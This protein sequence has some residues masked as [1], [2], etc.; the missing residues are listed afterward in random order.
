[1]VRCLGVSEDRPWRRSLSLSDHRH[2]RGNDSPRPP[3]VGQLPVGIPTRPHP[4]TGRRVQAQGKKT[5]NLI[6]D[7]LALVEEHTGGNPMGPQKW[8]RRSLRNLCRDLKRHGHK[9]CAATI[10]KLLKKHDYTPK[11]N[12]KRFTGPRHPDRDRQ[13]RWIARQRKAFLA[14]SLPVI[15]VDLKKRELVGNFKNPGQSWSQE[16]EE[17]DAYDFPSDAVGV[18]LPYGI[19]LVNRQHG[20]IEVGTS[21]ATPEFAVDAI[22]RWWASRGQVWFPTAD[23]LL[24]L[25][26]SGGNNGCRPR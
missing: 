25:A 5:P 17:V 15:S 11:A 26:D 6:S 4:A 13:F 3:R 14:K 9:A 1:M 24:I 2:E 22:A 20:H 7:L 8:V 18:A 12:R 19:Y 21:W 23:R 16:A 10:G